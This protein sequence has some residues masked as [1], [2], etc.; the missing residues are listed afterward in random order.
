MVVH[1]LS[2]KMVIYSLT[3]M[4]WKMRTKV[5]IVLNDRREIDAKV[6]GSDER[7]DVALLKVTGTNFPRTTHRGMLSS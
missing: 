1:F 3:T 6:V 2:V 4:W 7:T 5:T